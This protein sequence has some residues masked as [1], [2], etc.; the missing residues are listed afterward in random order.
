MDI[1]E[2]SSYGF[3]YTLSRGP[4]YAIP[5]HVESCVMRVRIAQKAITE[6]RARTLPTRN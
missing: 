3:A 1:Q 4:R 5:L 6:T 2:H